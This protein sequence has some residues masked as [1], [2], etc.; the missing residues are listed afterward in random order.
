MIYI[1]ILRNFVIHE[2]KRGSAAIGFPGLRS[3]SR[4]QYPSHPDGERL[5]PEFLFNTDA[6]LNDSDL[7]SIRSRLGLGCFSTT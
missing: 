4:N 5:D 1:L 6:L 2:G 3:L 7:R